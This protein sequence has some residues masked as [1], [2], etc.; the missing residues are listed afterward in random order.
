MYVYVPLS[1]GQ[2][3]PEQ[4]QLLV[5]GLLS[6]LTPH[7]TALFT[8]KEMKDTTKIVISGIVAFLMSCL[9]VVMTRQHLTLSDAATTWAVLYPMSQA[10]YQTIARKTGVKQIEAATT[11]PNLKSPDTDDTTPPTP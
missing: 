6:L 1:V 9:T 2:F 3:T 5:G 11:L 8:R 4:S 7:L 10:Y